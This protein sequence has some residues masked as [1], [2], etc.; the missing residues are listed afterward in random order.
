MQ[1]SP[2]F[3]LFLSIFLISCAHS[4]SEKLIAEEEIL[5]EQGNYKEAIKKLDEAIKKDSKN[6]GAYI[7]RGTNKSAL[8]DFEGANSDYQKALELIPGNRLSLFNIGNNYKRLGKPK[9]AVE[10]YNKALHVKDGQYVF[11]EFVP[12]ENTDLIEFYVPTYQIIYERGMAYYDLG[13][14]EYAFHDF[15]YALE[16]NFESAKCHYFLGMVHY[17]GGQKDKACVE[18]NLA[19]QLNDKDAEKSFQAYCTD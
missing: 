13:E 1:K 12:N 4:Q 19:K 18:F 6:A 15:N 16:K 10:N 17:S 2:I 8:E 5:Y 11:V 3:T 14:L 7:N 9:L